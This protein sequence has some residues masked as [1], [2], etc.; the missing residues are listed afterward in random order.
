MLASPVR[1]VSS[2]SFGPP[3]RWSKTRL[4]QLIV[5]SK[6]LMRSQTMQRLHLKVFSMINCR[7]KH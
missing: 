1:E 7:K 6:K 5:N 4:K 3:K 2:P